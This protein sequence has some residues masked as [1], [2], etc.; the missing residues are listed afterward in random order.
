MQLVLSNNRVI[1]YGENF[2]A[3]GG[4]VINTETGA[5]YENATIAECNGCPSDID[6]VGYEYHAGVFVPCAPFG[7]G[8]NNGYF[9]EVCESCATPRSSGI[10]IKGGLELE[11][12]SKTLS[13]QLAKITLLWENASPYSAFDQQTLCVSQD[14]NFEADFFVILAIS[15]VERYGTAQTNTIISTVIPSNESGAINGIVG[16]ADGF[17]WV[18]PLDVEVFR[19][20]RQR[21]SNLENGGK[22]TWLVFGEATCYIKDTDGTITRNNNQR[23]VCVP[24]RIYGVKL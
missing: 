7:V 20:V 9:M 2:L 10:P 11:N 12:L 23:G 17:D 14:A 6:K 16:Y 21:T 1:A 18:S 15:A 4:V 19:G 13:K 3:M 5:R 8:N 22:N 24:Y